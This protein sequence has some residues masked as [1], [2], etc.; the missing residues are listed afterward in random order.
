MSH[1]GGCICGLSVLQGISMCRIPGPVFSRTD[2]REVIR[3][4][5]MSPP[6][7][8]GFGSTLDGAVMPSY[9]V[10]ERNKNLHPGYVLFCGSLRPF[11]DICGSLIGDGTNKVRLC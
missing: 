2:F 4:A 7:A 10:S 8:K 1:G 9:S 3:L 6:S 5:L 11:E